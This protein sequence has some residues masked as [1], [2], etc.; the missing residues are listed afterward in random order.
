MFQKPDSGMGEKVNFKA[1]YSQLDRERGNS[2]DDLET[3]HAQL[4]CYFHLS[5][6]LLSGNPDAGGKGAEFFLLLLLLVKT[7]NLPINWQISGNDPP[8]FFSAL[9]LYCSRLSAG[10]LSY[11]SR[12]TLKR[13]DVR[14]KFGRQIRAQNSDLASSTDTKWK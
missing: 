14:K 3:S 9:Q 12:S 11:D 6:R 4:F 2:D 8:K 13:L 7:E 1:I 5:T 10:L